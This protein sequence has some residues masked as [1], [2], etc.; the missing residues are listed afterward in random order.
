MEKKRQAHFQ[1]TKP[2]AYVKLGRRTKVRYKRPTGRHN[3]S[4]QKWRSRPPMVEIGYKNQCSTRGL[5]NG[6]MPVLVY[7]LNDLAKVG[8]E[9]IIIIGKI[10]NRLKMEIAKKAE[11]NK[12]EIFN[13][14]VKK[15]LKEAGRKNKKTGENKE[16]KK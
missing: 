12:M 16:A 15:F 9:N 3:K 8:K 2:H 6:K 14:N 7:N 11:E 10:G 13:L 5:I 1:R 4:R